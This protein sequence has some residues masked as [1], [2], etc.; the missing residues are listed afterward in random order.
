MIK[1]MVFWDVTSCSLI[2][3]YQKFEEICYLSTT[4]HDV[5]SQTVIIFIFTTMTSELNS[6]N[7][8]NNYHVLHTQDPK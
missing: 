3:R 6:N 2:A 7:D 4:Q 5:T 1:I 8:V